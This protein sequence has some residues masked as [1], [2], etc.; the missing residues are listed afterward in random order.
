MAAERRA[1]PRIPIRWDAQVEGVGGPP[2]Q[3][4]I[5]DFCDGG[6]FL[7]PGSEDVR[8]TLQAGVG[9]GT[10]LSVRFYDPK[11]GSFRNVRA[12]VVRQSGHGI[13]VAFRGLEPDAVN[14]LHEVASRQGAESD[15][16]EVAEGIERIEPRKA[17]EVVQQ[18]RPVITDYFNI[19]FRNFARHAENKLFEWARASR[20]SAEQSAYLEATTAL[21]NNYVRLGQAFSK[22]VLDGLRGLPEGEEANHAK[23]EFNAEE[24][25]QLSLVNDVEF[26]DWL[27][28]S[29]QISR[30]ET[31]NARQLEMIE[32]RLAPLAGKPVRRESNPLSPAAFCNAFGDSLG[33]LSLETAARQAVYRVFG[34]TF[35][36]HLGELYEVINRTLSENGI[37][38]DLENER[39]Q[40]R[41][42][43]GGRSRAPVQ[44]PEAEP[45]AAA[46]ETSAAEAPAQEPQA[47][48]NVVPLNEGRR[49]GRP[50][51]GGGGDASAAVQRLR[52]LSKQLQSQGGGDDGGGGAPAPAGPRFETQEVLGALNT[53]QARLIN[54]ATSP[55]TDPG[56]RAR[57]MKA[58]EQSDSDKALSEE[59]M[60]Q[61]EQLDEWFTGVQQDLLNTDFLREWSGKLSVLALR[62]QLANGGF[63]EEGSHPIHHLLNQLDKAGI[64]LATQQGEQK[65]ELQR[66]VEQVLTRVLSN[67]ESSNEDLDDAA[68]ELE[69]MIQAPLR[70]RTVNL[71]KMLQECEGRQRLERAKRRAAQA[72]SDRLGGLTVPRVLVELVQGAWQNVLVLVQLRAGAESRDWHEGIMAVERLR[73]A[74]GTADTKPEPVPNIRHTLRFVDGQLEAY[75]RKSGKMTSIL[76]E[77]ER[78]IEAGGYPDGERPEMA[79]FPAYEGNDDDA[80]LEGIEPRWVGLAKLMQVGNWV[81]FAGRDGTPEPLR[82][83][84]VSEDHRQFV[85]S[86][87]NGQKGAELTLAELAK[88]LQAAAAGL[89]EDMDEPLTERQ[90]Q[91]R[92]NEMNDELLHQA[93]HDPLTGSLN[94]HTFQKRLRSLLERPGHTEHRG[95]IVHFALDGFKVVNSTLGY[96]AGDELLKQLTKMLS[97]ELGDHDLLGRSGG[98]EFTVYLDQRSGDQGRIYAEAKRKNFN[99]RGFRWDNDALSVSVSVGVVPFIG[100]E[101][102]PAQL[103]K[104]ADEAALAAKNAGGNRLHVV[105]PDDSELQTLRVS[106]ERAASLDSALNTGM[107]QLRC[108]RIEPIGSSINAM[109]MYEVLIGMQGREKELVPPGQFIPAAERFGRM[110]AVD[111]WVLQTLCQWIAD[112]AH[113]LRYLEALTVNLSAQTLTDPGFPDFVESQ[114]G[115]HEI[116]ARK[117]CFEVTETAAVANLGTAADMIRDLKGL[118]CRFALDD[119]GSGLASY[120]Y[121]KNLPVDFL[122]IDGEL[123]RGIAEHKTDQAVVKSINELSH[124]LGK[125]TVGEFVESDAI[126]QRLRELGLDYAQGYQVERPIPI[127]ELNVGH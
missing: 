79:E 82:L 41:N 16:R 95:V 114:F 112:H 80:A 58:L 99:E 57:V 121:L 19:R 87:R 68:G 73:K 33:L 125:S 31:R 14:A 20:S 102:Q 64:A 122:K 103:I 27:I 65:R 61:V 55:D 96:D 88:Q 42:L 84:W 76:S 3:F 81:F 62:V 126:L 85:F 49:Q 25:A 32:R 60:D 63:L 12:R 47:P 13:G 93:T 59:H 123:I 9:A 40:V 46:G 100:A 78:I 66:G 69:H 115:R 72:M 1:Y 107:L 117:I 75:S 48:G 50:S 37:L 94:R 43:D 109:P 118:G 54:E 18:V 39:Y 38:P 91:R 52:E 74:L 77:L 23:R 67:K 90:W 98:D 105:T 101:Y 111:R 24:S 108:Q 53:I 4:V 124:Y 119:F 2:Q 97:E 92:L 10:P 110:A 127:D 6:L 35:M 51:G 113:R 22:A 15:R 36:S 28:R 44:T 116:E 34:Q 29:E 70:T 7:A 26:E 8:A 5:S 83:S 71:Q 11:A 17:R 106:M 45:Q 56:L 30:S 21:R 89:A 104:D 86:R 120:A